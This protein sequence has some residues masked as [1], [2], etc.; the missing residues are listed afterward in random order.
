MVFSILELRFI[1]EVF[2]F[3]LCIGDF[4][5]FFKLVIFV[6]FLGYCFINSYSI[7]SI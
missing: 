1:E 7:Y 5:V 2:L 6:F 4:S 3:G